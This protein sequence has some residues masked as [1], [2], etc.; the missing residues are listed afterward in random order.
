MGFHGSGEYAISL[1]SLRRVIAPTLIFTGDKDE[2]LSWEEN[3]RDLAN[4]LAAE[5]NFR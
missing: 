2:E 4:T 5:K 1:R 3:A